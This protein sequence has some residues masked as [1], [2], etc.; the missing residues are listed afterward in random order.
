VRNATDPSKQYFVLL[1]NYKQGKL[2]H[3]G[4]VSLITMAQQIGDTADYRQLLSSYYNYLHKQKKEKLYT[5]ENIE[6]IASTLDSSSMV[7]FDM[8][9]Q[10]EK[11]VNKV[12]Q[13]DWYTKKVVG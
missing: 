9:Y 13:N 2:D 5:K 11:E 7:L 8:F 6:F 3:A 1:K 4:T 12:M 10:N